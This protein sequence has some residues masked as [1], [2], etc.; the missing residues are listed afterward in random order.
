MLNYVLL[1]L[2]FEGFKSSRTPFKET[3]HELDFMELVMFQHHYQAW[4]LHF[5]KGWC[6]I[7]DILLQKLIDNF[8]IRWRVK[9]AIDSILFLVEASV[10]LSQIVITWIL[11]DIGVGLISVIIPS[12]LDQWCLKLLFI[13]S[14][15]LHTDLNKHFNYFLQIYPFDHLTVP[16]L[17]N[18]S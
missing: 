18:L 15:R 1:E 9:V 17:L 3:V 2:L 12:L 10:G 4:V 14:F 11:W 13:N 7:F 6:M 5:Q 8:I 16:L